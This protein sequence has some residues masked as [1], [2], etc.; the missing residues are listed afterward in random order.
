MGHNC[1]ERRE[2]IIKARVV[3]LILLSQ[4]GSYFAQAARRRP[5]AGEMSTMQTTIYSWET[6]N[7]STSAPPWNQRTSAHCHTTISPVVTTRQQT[8]RPGLGAKPK[9]GSNWKI[10]HKPSPSTVTQNNSCVEVKADSDDRADD[11][12]DKRKTMF[13]WHDFRSA[14]LATTRRTCECDITDGARDVE[15]RVLALSDVSMWQTTRH[16]GAPIMK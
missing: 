14:E 2:I 16:V 8:T 12:G 1:V 3:C 10:C 11:R 4:R 7:S 6:V 13:R 5:T 15:E 9:L